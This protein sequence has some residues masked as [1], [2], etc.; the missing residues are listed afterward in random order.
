MTR[1]IGSWLRPVTMGACAAAV[2]FNL[3]YLPHKAMRECRLD[4][5]HRAATEIDRIVGRDEPLYTYKLGDEPASLIFYLDRDAPPI[6]TRLGDA[7]PGYVIAP[8]S[9]WQAEQESAPEMIPVFESKSGKPPIVLLRHGP[10]LAAVS[11]DVLAINEARTG[12]SRE[13]LQSIAGKTRDHE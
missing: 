9:V 3:I 13:G 8:L 6:A 4:S 2:L 7:P 11:F 5:M 1:A 10:A 12:R